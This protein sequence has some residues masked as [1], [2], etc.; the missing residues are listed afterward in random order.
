MKEYCYQFECV[1]INS[2]DDGD[3][4]DGAQCPNQYDCRYCVYRHEDCNE[5]QEHDHDEDVL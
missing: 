3:D 1:L 5:I 2:C 4:C